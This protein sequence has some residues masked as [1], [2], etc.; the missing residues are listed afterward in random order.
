MAKVIVPDTIARS[1]QLHVNIVCVHINISNGRSWNIS[2]VA[3]DARLRPRALRCF[4]NHRAN[5]FGEKVD[6]LNRLAFLT[7]HHPMG[8]TNW[9]QPVCDIIEVFTWQTRQ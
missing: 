7:K 4:C 8:E 2:I 9:L 6:V 3:K 1:I 5:A